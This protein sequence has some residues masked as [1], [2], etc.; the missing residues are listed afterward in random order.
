MAATVTSCLAH[1]R[2]S[3]KPAD[4]ATSRHVPRRLRRP[5]A[6]FLAYTACSKSATARVVRGAEAANAS[7]ACRLPR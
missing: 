4:R 5:A 1:S 3:L 6:V 7:A 2:D